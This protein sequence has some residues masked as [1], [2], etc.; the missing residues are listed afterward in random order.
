M[1]TKQV[2]TFAAAVLMSATLLAAPAKELTREHAA[3]IMA[4]KETKENKKYLT[5]L[6]TE[7]AKAAK[8]A[9]DSTSLERALLQGN[10]DLLVVVTRLAEKNKV[11]ALKNVLD[12]SASVKSETD[13]SLLAKIAEKGLEEIVNAKGFLAEIKDESQKNG[14]ALSE[15]IK[16]A[17]KK[18][19]KGEDVDSWIKKL[20]ECIA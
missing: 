16:I 13:A 18:F 15:A 2:L 3:K 6:S 9:G 20:L 8:S 7:V 11:A 12:L 10:P 4:T 14:T 5:E 1:N 19:A 17:A